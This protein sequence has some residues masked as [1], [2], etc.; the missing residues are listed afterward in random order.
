MEPHEQGL[1][2]RG[3]Y[4]GVPYRYVSDAMVGAGPSPSPFARRFDPAHIARIRA[5]G[6]PRDPLQ[7]D[8]WLA[9]LN[10]GDRYV[11]DG[12]PATITVP[13][14]LVGKIRVPKGMTLRSF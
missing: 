10:R 9:Q 3:A 1:T 14:D 4:V 5:A 6:G 7:I 2:T 13:T 11:S 12:D 8:Y